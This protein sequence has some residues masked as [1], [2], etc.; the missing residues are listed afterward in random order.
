MIVALLPGAAALS[1]AKSEN[2]SLRKGSTEGIFVGIEQGDYAHFQIKNEAAEEESCFLRR[3]DKPS[4]PCLDHP[5]ILKGGNVRG[6]W[7]EKIQKIPE[8]GE[9]MRLKVVVRAETPG[10]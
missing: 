10:K 6:H 5:E 3:P 9:I 2:E 7:Q 8:A 1:S 4:Q